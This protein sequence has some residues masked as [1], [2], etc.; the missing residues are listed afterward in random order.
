MY[1][2]DLFLSRHAGTD[3]YLTTS[4][5]VRIQNLTWVER[6]SENQFFPLPNRSISK[7]TKPNQS[8][9]SFVKVISHAIQDTRLRRNDSSIVG[10][11]DR[12]M[13]Q[14]IFFRLFFLRDR[15]RVPPPPPPLSSPILPTWIIQGTLLTHRIPCEERTGISFS[16][17]VRVGDPYKLKVSE[18]SRQSRIFSSSVTVGS[19]RIRMSCLMYMHTLPMGLT[20]RKCWGRKTTDIGARVGLLPFRSAV[21]FSTTVPSCLRRSRGFAETQQLGM[22]ASNVGLVPQD[23]GDGTEGLE[24]STGVERSCAITSFSKGTHRCVLGND[25]N[26]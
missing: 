20:F 21:I 13:G 10:D 24:V 7:T 19:K 22:F 1:V 18:L 3:Q 9:I 8:S 12:E 2:S 11:Q 4:G 6:W 14:K 16:L 17:G 25:L 15:S 26:L 5:G 23:Q